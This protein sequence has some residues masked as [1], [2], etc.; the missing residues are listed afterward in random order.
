VFDMEYVCVFVCVCG[1][2]DMENVQVSVH[3]MCVRVCIVWK[4]VCVCVIYV[5]VREMC[6]ICV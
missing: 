4:C 6:V 2:C 3:V 5:C 1:A